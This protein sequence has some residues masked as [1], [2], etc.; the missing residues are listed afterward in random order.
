LRDLKVTAAAGLFWAEAPVA[1][2]ASA[3]AELEMRRRMRFME[4]VGLA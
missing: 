1:M 2:R 3:A 4:D